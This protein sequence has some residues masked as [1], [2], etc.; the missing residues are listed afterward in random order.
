MMKCVLEPCGPAFRNGKPSRRL[1]AREENTSVGRRMVHFLLVILLLVLHDNRALRAPKAA[2]CWLSCLASS[3]AE[4]LSGAQLVCHRHQTVCAHTNSGA[5][6]AT[7]LQ[8]LWHS[9]HCLAS[10]SPHPILLSSCLSRISLVGHYP[11]AWKFPNRKWQSEDVAARVHRQAGQRRKGLWPQRWRRLRVGLAVTSM[12]QIQIPFILPVQMKTQR[13]DPLPRRDL[14]DPRYPLLL[15]LM[16]DH[17]RQWLRQVCP[18][19]HRFQALGAAPGTPAAALAAATAAVA[20]T[21]PGVTATTAPTSSSSTRPHV[22]ISLPHSLEY[23][24]DLVVRTD[25]RIRGGSSG[26]AD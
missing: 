21:I 3:G 24:L 22:T 1:Q 10:I 14:R 15:D 17:R 8:S 11:C 7:P 5:C 2:H 4:N 26:T 18:H 12:G 20:G 23:D 25:P 19:Y 6:R 9:M 16:L 13:P